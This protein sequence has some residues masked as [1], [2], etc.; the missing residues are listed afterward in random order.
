MAAALAAAHKL[1][2]EGLVNLLKETGLQWNPDMVRL[3]YRV[4]KMIS[5]DNAGGVT[6]QGTGSLSP[7]QILYGGKK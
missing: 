3:L 6:K 4:N 7:A 1:A 2:G 5:E